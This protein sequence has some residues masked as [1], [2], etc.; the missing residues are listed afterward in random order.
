MGYN[1]FKVVAQNFYAGNS[2][3]YGEQSMNILDPIVR[4]G[5]SARWSAAQTVR[6]KWPYSDGDSVAA[7]PSSVSNGWK[8]QLC[9]F[10]FHAKR[11]A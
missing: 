10:D 4:G 2:G 11:D 1:R 3:P 9:W 5:W 8:E 7:C 6:E